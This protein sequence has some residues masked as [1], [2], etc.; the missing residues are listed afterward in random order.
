MD[1]S[2]CVE[3]L[4]RHGIKPTSNRI[5]VVKA[6]GA[7]AVPLSMTELENKILTI[8]KSGIFRCLTLFR[9]HHLVHLVEDGE[10]GMKYE[11]RRSGDH[12]DDDDMHVHFFC[13]QCKRLTCLYDTPVP[14][15]NAPAGSLLHSVNLTMRGICAD[16]MARNNKRA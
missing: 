1:E 12:D 11:L 16:C 8:D 10:G 5:V 14:Q 3:L 7:A 6:L 4:Q 9:E 2:F 15:T 13:E